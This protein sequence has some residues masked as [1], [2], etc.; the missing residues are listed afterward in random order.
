MSRILEV[1]RP[2][3][4]R[5]WHLSPRR[6]HAKMKT[7]LALLALVALGVWLTRSH[8]AN[9]S[10]AAVIPSPRVFQE[11]RTVEIRAPEGRAAIER[12]SPNRPDKTDGPNLSDEAALNLERE[13]SS[14]LRSSESV[15]RDYAL[16]TLLPGLMALD[17]EVAAYLADHWEPGPIRAELLLRVSRSWSLSDPAAALAWSASLPDT[18]ERINALSEVCGQIS[19]TDPARAVAIAERFNI[20]SV[21]G[22]IENAAQIWANKDFPA[23]L[24]WARHQPAGDLRDQV[25]ARIAFIQAQTVPAEAARLVS[26][27]IPPGPAQDE[28]VISVLHQWGLQD[29]AKAAA[30]V[31]SFASG[32]LR[33]KAIDE[34]AGTA[35]G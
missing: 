12:P 31:G 35:G 19:Q 4:V 13:I 2:N 6:M 27:E 22:T 24:D 30:W 26:T 3:V 10:P 33:E 15:R 7:T 14:A 21:G 9:R 17:P 16:A 11:R 34:L 1:L 8:P 18:G 28:A 23:A 32:P 20:G 5:N 29:P 25:I